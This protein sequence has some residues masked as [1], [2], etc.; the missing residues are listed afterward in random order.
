MKLITSSLLLLILLTLMV[1]VSAGNVSIDLTD[2]DLT[3]NIDILVYDH[4]GERVGEYQTGENFTLNSSQSYIFVVKPQESS[5]FSDPLLA[6]EY[7]KLTLPIYLNYILFL[8]AFLS[9]LY[10]V[11][12]SCLETKVRTIGLRAVFLLFLP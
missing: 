11:S 10:L 8:V 12:R 6:I 2:L 1:P 7:L 5:I 9:G 3:K 4:T